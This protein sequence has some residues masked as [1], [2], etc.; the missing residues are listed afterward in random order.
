MLLLLFL[1]TPA[2]DGTTVKERKGSDKNK[3]LPVNKVQVKQ[4]IFQDMNSTRLIVSVVGGERNS[5]PFLPSLR[6]LTKGALFVS[7]GD[8]FAVQEPSV[9]RLHLLVSI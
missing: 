4:A 5:V 6:F 1:Y 8:I 2:E 3:P 7:G 9:V